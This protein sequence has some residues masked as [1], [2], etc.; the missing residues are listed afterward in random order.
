[1]NRIFVLLL[2]LALV[3][4]CFAEKTETIHYPRKDIEPDD[5][6]TQE[7]LEKSIDYLFSWQQSAGAFG[8]LTLHGC[9]GETSV[10]KR[11]YHGQ[12]T[13]ANR[14][15]CNIMLDMYEATGDYKWK[16]R[17]ESI[18]ANVMF[19]QA[20]SGGF[21]HATGEF[22]PAYS[23]Y[24]TCAIHQGEPEL[25]LLD[26]AAKPYADPEL[27]KEIKKVIDKHW[28]WF[29]KHFY[30]S[31]QK[32]VKAKKGWPW[33]C[34]SGVTNQD[35][36]VI[37][38]LA[39]YG[40]VY[41]DMSRYEKFGKPA[42]DVLLSDRYYYKGLGLFQ[43]GDEP[44]WTYVERTPYYD[45]VLTTLRRIH[46]ITGDKRIPSILDDICEQL[47]R[48]TFVGQDGLRYFFHGANIKIDNGKVEIISYAK[49]PISVSSILRFMEFFDWYLK[50]H[51]DAEK[52]KIQNELYRT[53][54]AYMRAD[55]TMPIAFNPSNDIFALAPTY[56]TSF[57]LWKLKGKIKNFEIEEV[58]ALQRRINNL[59]WYEKGQFYNVTRDG[60]RD[61]AGYKLEPKGIVL[62]ANEGMAKVDF[63]RARKYGKNEK[64]IVEL[65][66]IKYDKEKT[67]IPS[68]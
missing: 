27:K 14:G 62:G 36:V 35:L 54:A 22:E 28:H 47:L 17:A 16:L 1:M 64:V 24:Q 67:F 44:A 11:K 59:V 42:L 50:K 2:S 30:Q 31:G 4:V 5:V 49:Y 68:K 18:V 38:A 15:F 29:N 60:V 37:E 9:W 41:N 61:F 57:L 56:P 46:Q 26:Y 52:Q 8:N 65:L 63:N 55:G 48:S 20:K 12:Y 39:V 43:R 40:K 25:A 23:E 32:A 21:Y 7:T 45:V 66:D 58:S 10:I 6:F 19:L 53:A 13:S 33:P 3:S 51:P 34:W